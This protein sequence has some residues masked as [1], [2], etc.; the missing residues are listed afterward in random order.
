MANV[1]DGLKLWIEFGA[2]VDKLAVE[3][4]TTSVVSV[5]MIIV[6]RTPYFFSTVKFAI[7]NDIFFCSV[8]IFMPH[9]F[10]NILPWVVTVFVAE[11][12][13]V[14]GVGVP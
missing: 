3:S 10:W 9:L 2:S 14:S 1:S 12:N 7:K 4:A 13:K 11:I 5:I 8:F 6:Q